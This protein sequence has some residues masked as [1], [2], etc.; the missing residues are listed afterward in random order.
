MKNAILEFNCK[1]HLSK[2]ILLCD[3]QL[4]SE[5]NDEHFWWITNL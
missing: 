5:E 4:I 2:E 1:I 3:V